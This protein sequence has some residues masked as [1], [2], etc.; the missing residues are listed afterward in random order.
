[1]SRRWDIRWCAAFAALALLATTAAA[2][3]GD[4][5]T[6]PAPAPDTGALDAKVYATLLKVTK[7]GITLY[8]SED[9]AGCYRLYEGS[10]M[11]IAPLLDHKPDLQ[12]AITRALA[13]AERDPQ[14]FRRAFALRTALDTI[15]KDLNPRKKSKPATTFAAGKKEAEKK[16]PNSTTSR[17]K[18]K[19]KTANSELELLPKPK[20]QDEKKQD[21][22]QGE[23]TKQEEKE[24]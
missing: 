21:G 4:E 5:K 16:K 23:Q 19:E 14:I 2:Q 17:V 3:K 20:L 15:L 10:L 7:R 8:N 9:H 24:D 18:T 12:K 1:M 11:T 13:A 6:N 22:K